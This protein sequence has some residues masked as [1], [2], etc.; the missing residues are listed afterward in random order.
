MDMSI[1]TDVSRK[2]W[3]GNDPEIQYQIHEHLRFGARNYGY[4]L[5][6]MKFT[7][8]NFEVYDIENGEAIPLTKVSASWESSSLPEI[9]ESET[10]LRDGT[11]KE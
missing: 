2:L 6:E 11:V 5:E 9:S 1:Q 7:S 10:P 3:E 8:Q 4:R